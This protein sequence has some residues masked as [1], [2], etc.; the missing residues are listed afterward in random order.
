MYLMVTHGMEFND[1]VA[2]MSLED[3]DF[4]FKHPDIFENTVASRNSGHINSGF[5]CY[6]G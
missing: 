2:Q 3:S 6:S 1:V 5:S 4:F